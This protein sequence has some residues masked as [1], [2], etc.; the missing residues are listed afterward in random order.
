MHDDF[1]KVYVGGNLN[2]NF[3]G[4]CNGVCFVVRLF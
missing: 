1:S 3:K 4:C 2:E